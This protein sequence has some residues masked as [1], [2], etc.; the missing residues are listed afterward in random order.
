[1]LVVIQV[2]SKK[3]VMRKVMSIKRDFTSLGK[4]LKGSEA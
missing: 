1:V 2:G 3:A 4:M